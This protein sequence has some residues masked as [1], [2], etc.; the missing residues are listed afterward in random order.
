MLT[1]TQLFMYFQS[2]FMFLIQKFFI[3]LAESAEVRLSGAAN[4]QH[5][6]VERNRHPD[7]NDTRE[8]VEHGIEL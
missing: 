6:L 3:Y 8:L 4:G 7:N 2:E 5:Q 1:T